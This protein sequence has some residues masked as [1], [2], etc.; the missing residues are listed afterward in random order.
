MTI[1]DIEH[2]KKLL[3]K[4]E[5]HHIVGLASFDKN[6]QIEVPIEASTEQLIAELNKLQAV[7]K[8][9]EL[10]RNTLKSIAT[11]TRIGADKKAIYLFSDGQ[12]EDKA[13]FHQDVIRAVRNFLVII[14]SIDYSQS[15]SL[16]VPCKQYVG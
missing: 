2:I 6:L 12:T 16:S 13:Y 1:N 8:T 15:V 3:A 10:Y 9:T 5:A 7:G 4:I 14:N 11:I